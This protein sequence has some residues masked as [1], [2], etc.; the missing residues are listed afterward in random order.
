MQLK[1]LGKMPILFF[2]LLLCCFF[3]PVQVFAQNVYEK[4]TPMTDMELKSF[5]QILPEFRAWAKAHKEKA[6][7]QIIKGK[8]DF[9]YS[10]AA[11]NWVQARNW[12]AR[13]FFSIMGKVAAALYIISEGGH[14]NHP[15]DMPSVAQAELD[16]VQEHLTKLLEA[17]KSTA[18][19][20]Q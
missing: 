2:M 3:T 6:Q 9:V 1:L 7:P 12:D 10:S 15:K 14:A 18:S 20:K 13:R 4:Q 8:A 19:I 11:K 16:L 17:S 5:I